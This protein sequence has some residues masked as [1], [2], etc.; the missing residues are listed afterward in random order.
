MR[1]PPVRMKG[2]MTKRYGGT[3]GTGRGVAASFRRVAAIFLLYAQHALEYKSRSLVWFLL[4]FIDAGVYL[5]YWRGVLTD[6]QTGS[7]WS[8]SQAVS[9]YLLLLVAGSFLEVHIEEEVAFEDIQY[10]RLSQYLLRPFPY[11]GFKFFQELPWRII[12]GGFGLLTL[13]VI[14]RF[15]S[16]FR[17]VSTPQEILPVLFI[18][19]N[20]YLLCFIYKMIVGSVSFWTTDY[21]G[22]QNI[23]TIVFLIF[24]GVLIP[25][26]LLPDAILQF[27]LAQPIAYMMYYPVVA[28]QGSLT[29]DGMWRVVVT[30]WAWILVLAVLFKVVWTRGLRA[31]TAVGQ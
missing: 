19:A 4:V 26:H 8:L 10:G 28:A 20:A 3:A 17:I 30:Q 1:N 9:Y 14:S 24:S 27:A 18:A 12:Q 25:L 15:F 21:T 29:P 2:I 22:M 16:Q 7:I 31:F 23:Q 11:A 13:V 5:L 6:P